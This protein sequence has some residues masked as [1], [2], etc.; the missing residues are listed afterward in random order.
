MLGA[1][2]VA[3]IACGGSSKRHSGNDGASAGEGGS[4]GSSGGVSGTG[5][6]S[7]T[8]G[9]GGTSGANGT[10][11][12]AGGLACHYRGVSIPPNTTFS[13]GCNDCFCRGG[14]IIDCPLEACSGCLY[15]GGFYLDG[16][17]IPSRDGGCC[18]CNGDDVECVDAPCDAAS[19]CQDLLDLYAEELTGRARDCN[20][21]ID[22]EQCLKPVS[23]GL[24]CGCPTFVNDW[25]RLGGLM[26]E[27][28]VHACGGDVTCGACPP[29][30]TSAYCS[31]EG[32]CVEE[33]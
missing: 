12:S 14:P 6:T 26:I 13:N 2:I 17:V 7:G 20:P 22:V 29:A 15:E 28:A 24:E 32:R 8:A 25:H 4:S 1:L 9:N 23:S 33:F 30:P 18:T 31:S 27:W 11:G 16:A 5:A 3:L 10:G 21:V 19:R